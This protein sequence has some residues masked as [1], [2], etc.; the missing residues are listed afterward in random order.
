MHLHRIARLGFALAALL[1]AAAA[2]A[3]ETGVVLAHPIYRAFYAC[4]EHPEGQLTEIGDALGSDCTVQQLVEV[5]GRLWA[6]SY[7]GEGLRNEDWYGWGADVL[8]PCDCTVTKL[9]ENPVTNKPGIMG[10]GIA[11][12]VMLRRDDGVN[13]VLAHI[14]KPRVKVGDHV[15]AGQVLAQVGNNGFARQPHIH[16]GAWRDKEPLQLRF[17]L[18]ASPP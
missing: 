7:R 6:R 18:R 8:S 9:N 3:A 14:A 15:D 1:F 13:F 16:I 12:F 11:S 10:S 5:K 17:D 4:A 2:N